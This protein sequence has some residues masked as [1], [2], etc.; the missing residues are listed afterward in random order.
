MPEDP[1]DRTTDYRPILP[2][3]SPRRAS[4]PRI[5]DTLS[6]LRMVRDAYRKPTIEPEGNPHDDA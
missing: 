1:L 5:A 6:A 2:E 3:H 4:R